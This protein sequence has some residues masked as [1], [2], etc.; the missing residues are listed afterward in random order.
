MRQACVWACTLS[1][2]STRGCSTC[3]PRRACIPGRMPVHVCNLGSVLT[4]VCAAISVLSLARVLLGMVCTR[5]E[6]HFLVRTPRQLAVCYSARS[7][8]CTSGLRA[9]PGAFLLGMHALLGMRCA[10]LKAYTP[11]HSGMWFSTRDVKCTSGLRTPG[12]CA[13]L[14]MGCAY[15]GG[16]R[17][18]VRT[19]QRPWSCSAPTPSCVFGLLGA[20]LMRTLALS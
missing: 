4:W 13:F 15:L 2:P 5:L 3:V 19:P 16:T 10:C 11:R 1:A 17:S 20:L 18:L 7:P 6:S 8:R 12:R 9:P 14:D